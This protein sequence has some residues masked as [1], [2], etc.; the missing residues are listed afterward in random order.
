[1]SSTGGD[2]SKFLDYFP[3]NEEYP[4]VSGE[5]LPLGGLWS[6]ISKSF[7]NGFVNYST[8]VKAFL[9][10]RYE[11]SYEVNR[12]VAESFN[13]E[14]TTHTDLSWLDDDILIL[15]RSKDLEWWFFWFDR[16]VSDCSIGRFSTN[17]DWDTVIKRFEYYVEE[18]QKELGYVDHKEKPLELD[19]SR[20]NGWIKA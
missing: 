6:Y 19:T 17:D 9:M 4:D 7:L 16:D 18:R 13:R 14:K 12:R 8:P 20:M 10:H 2:M 1:M 5:I 11:P 15:S 3:Y